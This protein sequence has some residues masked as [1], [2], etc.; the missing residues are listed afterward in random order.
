MFDLSAYDLSEH[1]FAVYHH[2]VDDIEPEERE[3]APYRECALRL[4]SVL[5]IA[6]DFVCQS[7]RPRMAMQQVGVAL[8]IPAALRMTEQEFALLNQVARDD[9]SEGVT[10]F[11]RVSQL[12]PA[13]ALKADAAKAAYRDCHNRNGAGASPESRAVRTSI[14]SRNEFGVSIGT[15]S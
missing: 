7:Q 3:T 2:P 13:L 14:G 10:K 6:Y 5:E 11:L 12:P 15:P 4:L 8:G 9:F 1:E